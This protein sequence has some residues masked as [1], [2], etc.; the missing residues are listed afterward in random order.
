M[1]EYRKALL[2]K[3]HRIFSS[4]YY[5]ALLGIQGLGKHQLIVNYAMSHK[6]SV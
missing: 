3:I 4:G 2:R 5:P 1:K 6:K